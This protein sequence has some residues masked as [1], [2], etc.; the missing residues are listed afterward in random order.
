MFGRFIDYTLQ[1]FCCTPDTY[2]NELCVCLFFSLRKYSIFA[3][4]LKKMADFSRNSTN[5][6][7]G[8]TQ[9][10]NILCKLPSSEHDP[11]SFMVDLIYYSVSI[12]V[13]IFVFVLTCN[14]ML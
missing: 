9:I 8:P 13:T 4:N 10:L 12:I 5:L 2:A 14:F 7:K 1:T 3:R 11:Y 6:Y